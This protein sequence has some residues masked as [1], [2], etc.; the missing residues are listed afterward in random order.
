[1][2]LRLEIFDS[3]VELIHSEDLDP[4]TVIK[5][6]AAVQNKIL[7]DCFPSDKADIILSVAK[8]LGMGEKS[9]EPKAFRPDDDFS[10]KGIF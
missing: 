9:N 4:L 1:M 7:N 10:V 6:L 8:I 2:H 3:E 5:M